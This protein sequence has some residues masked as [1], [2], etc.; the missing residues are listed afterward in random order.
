M[1]SAWG[2]APFQKPRNVPDKV[3]QG[4]NL[5]GLSHCGAV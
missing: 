1:R 2:A 5:V 4:T 3:N